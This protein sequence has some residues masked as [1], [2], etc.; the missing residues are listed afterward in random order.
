MSYGW[1]LIPVISAF[2][3]WLANRI[4]V[5]MLFYPKEPRKIFGFTIQGIIPKKQAQLVEKLGKL[6]SEELF[7]FADITQK[8]VD[9]VHFQKLMPLIEEHVDDF[10][11]VKLPVK[12]PMISMFIGDKTINELKTVFSAEVEALFPLVMKNYIN[13]LQDEIDMKKRIAEKLARFSSGKLELIL[14]ETMGRELRRVGWIGA[15]I[16][17]LMGLLLVLI[18]F[19]A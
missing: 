18:L 3:G 6:V 4:L 11:R 9:P 19:L 15:I 7:S 14:K 10:L 13:G 2:T 17:F 8:A 12:M 16:G 1:V 5:K